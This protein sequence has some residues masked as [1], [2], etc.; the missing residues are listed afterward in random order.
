[1]AE[2]TQVAKCALEFWRANGERTKL[3]LCSL[4]S[5]FAQTNNEMNNLEHHERSAIAAVRNW[6]WY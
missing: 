4:V 2:T 6:E 3:R 5:F 1:M